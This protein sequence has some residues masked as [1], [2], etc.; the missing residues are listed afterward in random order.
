MKRWQVGDVVV[1]RIEESQGPGFTP[2]QLFNDWTDEAIAPHLDWLQPDY[3]DPVAGR[4][5]TSIH[6]WLL[7]TPAHTIL[8]DTCAGNHKE[9][10][11]SPRFHHLDTP[12]L[13]RLEAAGVHTND[14]DIV[15]CTHLH[16]DHVGWNT[17]LSNGRWVPTFPNAR[18]VFSRLE[19]DH[20][21]P[22]DNPS[23]VERYP[24]KEQIYQDSVLPV[25]EA[26][27]AHFSDGSEAI[28]DWVTVEPAP[29]HTPGHIVVKLA[30]KGRKAL[31]SGDIL[32][33]PIQIVNP[34]WNSMF[35]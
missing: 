13:Q 28:D 9:R 1:T 3:F 11:F 29:G 2:Q 22:V 7:Q 19:H 25:V 35:C 15:M 30:S 31:F 17:R 5:V 10:S 16:V 18:Y 32:H 26:G 14:V 4:L 6:T 20:W 23:I 27:L 34:G 12:W 21:S 8:I 33:H 24:L